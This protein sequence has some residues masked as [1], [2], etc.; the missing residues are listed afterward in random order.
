MGDYSEREAIDE[1]VKILGRIY[2]S[3]EF[4]FMDDA[5]GLRIG[6]RWLLYK[7]DG[8]PISES[9]Y[10]GMG[11]DDLAFR[12]AAGA[13][14][15]I[16]AKGGRPEIV[17]FSVGIP[18][19]KATQ[20]IKDIARGIRDFASRNSMT[21]GGGDT[22]FVAREGW[23]DVAILGFTDRPI[24]NNPLREGEVVKVSH[25][26]G[27]SSIPAIAHYLGIGKGYLPKVMKS[28]KR[29]SL[30]LNFLHYSYK[31]KAS[32]DVSDGLESVRKMLR[33]SG[34]SLNLTDPREFLCPEAQEFMETYGIDVET[35]LNF[36][37]E[38]YSI[39]FTGGSDEGLPLGIL[40]KGEVGC[41]YLNGKVLEG[42]WD[43]YIGF[44]M[45]K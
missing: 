43:N 1:A 26:L 10:E 20:W 27:I 3:V 4:G 21:V 17:F 7:I 39:I 24:P 23:L 30:P 11:V 37:G 31:V 14:T 5:S 28:I 35:L 8:T 29:P 32:T 2:S 38:E 33:L 34:L 13:A 42:G 36:M 12:V 40:S 18:R 44:L 6:G 41:I 19:S 45:R 15:D 25:C 22:N 16:I 9:M